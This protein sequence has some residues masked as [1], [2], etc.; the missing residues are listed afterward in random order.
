MGNPEPSDWELSQTLL[1]ASPISGFHFVFAYPIQE[2]KESWKE[3]KD[4]DP[5]HTS[6]GKVHSSTLD[7]GL[8]VLSD[9]YQSSSFSLLGGISGIGSLNFSLKGERRE[10]RMARDS[11]KH[12]LW[13][14]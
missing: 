2:S 5:F 7:V 4:F 8:I 14:L 9:L 12:S 13:H 11:H 6:F 1:H 10:T 3:D